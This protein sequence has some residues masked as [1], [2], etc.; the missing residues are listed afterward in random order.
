VQEDDRVGV[1]LPLVLAGAQLGKQLGR[2]RIA[3]GVRAAVQ[4]DEQR[5]ERLVRRGRGRRGV[6]DVAGDDLP[7]DLPVDR[8]PVAGAEQQ[9]EREPGRDGT[10]GTTRDPARQVGGSAHPHPVHDGPAQGAATGP[11][12]IVTR[13]GAAA[14]F[15][16][17]ATAPGAA[18]PSITGT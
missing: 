7:V 15:G 1:Q 3:R 6:D 17:A 18:S 16:D 14:P 4:A 11:V 8:P 2:Q 9:R 12:R 13:A 5:G 10:R